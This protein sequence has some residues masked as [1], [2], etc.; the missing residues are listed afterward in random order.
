[1]QPKDKAICL[2][3]IREMRYQFF[4][5]LITIHEKAWHYI[6]NLQ[7]S[8]NCPMSAI[9]IIDFHSHSTLH[10]G[11]TAICRWEALRVHKQQKRL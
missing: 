5:H 2:L 7:D 8:S 1:M 11:S 6:Q 10:P 3:R 4:R 9:Y